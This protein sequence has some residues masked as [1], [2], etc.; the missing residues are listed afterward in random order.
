[1]SM[2]RL[3]ECVE[4]SKTTICCNDGRQNDYCSNDHHQCQQPR[5]D[6]HHSCL[7]VEHTDSMAGRYLV[8][9]REARA[10]NFLLR[11]SPVAMGPRATSS[12]ICLGCHEAIL[13][14]EFPRCPVC[15]WPL[16]SAAC[17]SSSLHQAE[18][19]VLA[20]DTSRIGQPKVTGSTPRYDIILVLRCLLLRDRNPLAWHRFLD[21]AS[22]AE[23]RMEE[24]EQHHMATVRY[25]K[26][27]LKVDYT[28]EDIHHARGAII[29]N[30]FEWRSPSGISLRG[31]YPLLGRMNHSCRPTVAV[32]SDCK[33]SMFVRA[34]V[35]LQPGDQLYI[36]YTDTLEP[37]WE[38]RAYTT[39]T[40]FFSCDC[41]R[42]RDPTELGLHY[43][44]PKCE[45]CDQQFLEPR[46]WLGEVTWECP[47]C[48]T[49]QTQQQVQLEVEQWLEH[50]DSD[51]TFLHTSPYAVRNIMDKVE[52]VF[53]PH[54]YVWVKAAH[55][56]L[57]TLLENHTTKAL[58]LKRHLWHRLLYIYNVLEPGLTKRRGAVPS[59]S[60][61]S[62]TPRLG[63]YVLSLLL[64]I[65]LHNIPRR[66]PRRSR[67]VRSR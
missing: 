48:G 11:E 50:F 13:G 51:D 6:D 17:A 10:G 66:S 25:I 16:C 62:P 41:V 20:A 54:H 36:T 24:K 65:H 23:R 30:C 5:N 45:L 2:E 34:A 19:P 29:T 57:R 60:S 32:S 42:C 53:H 61:W 40:H 28:L 26:E 22:H 39:S 18:C 38:R 15:W 59:L 44:S 64:Y 46:N 1:M 56:A 12:L 52:E 37:L 27:I 63:P 43:S 35:D 7:V 49:Q 9:S 33:G 47:L 4:E 67:N 8:T 14:T 55:V 58:D 3:C 31:V 21:M